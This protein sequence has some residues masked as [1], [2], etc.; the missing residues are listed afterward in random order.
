MLS[1]QYRPKNKLC[2]TVGEKHHKDNIE[3]SGK[4][5]NKDCCK[6]LCE[7]GKAYHQTHKN[8]CEIYCRESKTAR[9][10][11]VAAG[12]WVVVFVIFI[13]AIIASILCSVFGVFWSNDAQDG[14]PMTDAISEIQ[15]G[16]QVDI[17][18]RIAEL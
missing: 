5:Y 10:G 18:K 14:A 3:A 17:D 4:R 13:I 7:N 15:G 8:D 2:Y 12:G 6:R 9:G 11:A 1:C 16:F